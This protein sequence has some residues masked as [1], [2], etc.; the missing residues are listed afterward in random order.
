MV[1]NASNAK[2]VDV[3]IMAG[4]VTYNPDMKLLCENI[5][6]ILPQVSALCV[7]DNG[8]ENITAIESYIC[9]LSDADKRVELIKNGANRGIAYALNRLMMSGKEAKCS[10]VITLDQDS[11]APHNLIESYSEKLFDMNVGIISPVINDRNTVHKHPE[12]SQERFSEVER[13][14]TSASLIS[15]QVWEEVGGF[16]EKLFIDCV[17]HDFCMRVRD[18]GF[19][20]FRDN[21]VIL[22]HTIGNAKEKRIL[23]RWI[24]VS[25]HSA[26]RKYY[27]IRNNIYLSRKTHRWSKYRCWKNIVT[28]YIKVILYEDHKIEKLSHMNKGLIDG[29]RM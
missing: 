13:C 8:S 18:N 5:N 12:R 11:V 19:K 29:F 9:S 27:Q 17:D 25:N 6:S 1:A 24:T 2:S 10:W 16:D 15:I 26:F 20:I 21:D 4:I 3:S 28:I 22:S 14:I 7:V 23:G